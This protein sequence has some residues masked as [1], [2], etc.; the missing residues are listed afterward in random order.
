MGTVSEMVRPRA[1]AIRQSRLVAIAG[2][3]LGTQVV[4]SVLGLAFWTV[5]ARGLAPALVGQLGSVTA[6]AMLLGAFGVCGGGTLLVSRLGATLV[7]ARRELLV[8]AVVTGLGGGALL[9]VAFGLAAWR[10][11]PAFRFL[12]PQHATFWLLIAA[13]ALTAVGG[14]FDQAM[15]VVGRP[16]MQ[17]VRNAVS[18]VLKIVVLVVALCAG[19]HDVVWGL[20]AWVV[21]QLSAGVFAL[22]AA[23]RL[24]PTQQRVTVGGIRGTAMRYWR[25]A[26]SHHG[27]NIALGAPSMLQPVII[28]AVISAEENALFTTVRLVSIFAFT[29]PYALAMALFASSAADPRDFEARAR[30]VFR[31]SF[32][33]SLALYAGLFVTAPVILG[34]FGPTYATAGVPYLRIIALACP[35]LVFKDQYIAKARTHRRLWRAMPYVVGSTVLEVAGT[36]VGVVVSGLTGAIVGWLLALGVGA[37]WVALKW[38]TERG[39]G[40]DGQAGLVPAPRADS[41]QKGRPR[42]DGDVS[43]VVR[44]YDL[45]RF[46]QLQ[47]CLESLRNQTMTPQEVIVV[48]DGCESLD[49]ALRRRGGAETI[50]A[51]DVNQGLSA[52]RNAG[53][54]RV[55]TGWVAFLDDDAT[56]EPTWLERLVDCTQELDV[57]GAGGWSEPAFDGPMP[58]W[59]PP[60]LLW[61]VGCSYRGMPTERTI[62][63]NVF[64]GCA[65][66]KADLFD[67]V[68][69]YDVRLG[70]RGSGVEGGEEADFS[71]RIASANPDARFAHVPDAVIHHRVGLAR[72]T[73]RY[74]LNRCY[75]DGRTKALIARRSGG[76]AL[77]SERSYLVSTLPRGV[78]RSLCSGRLQSALL[79]VFGVVSAVMGYVAGRVGPAPSPSDVVPVHTGVHI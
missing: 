57:V 24:M 63:R 36:L 67:L 77:S 61:T 34:V 21:G 72:L 50:V 7:G 8:T 54:A 18:S 20:A 60:E 3:I 25:E 23:L 56:A 2:S 1:A 48:V 55:S 43:V 10:L 9:A 73:R 75:S 78:C 29:A 65:V 4:T 53:V 39:R 74:I 32:G 42:R 13:A 28:A 26:A 68:G 30:T 47:T 12:S 64:G 31:L 27:M 35:L 70:R 40:Q 71:L 6:A 33:L 58:R 22:V 45:A 16:I 11:F 41:Q 51:L 5:A 52:A 37:V 14:L 49:L 15:L 76:G 69:G 19:Y 66:L 46:D 44:T 79:L 38:R 17:V 59:F 62:R